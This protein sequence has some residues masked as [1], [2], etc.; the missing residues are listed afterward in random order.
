MKLQIVWFPIQT[1]VSIAPRELLLKQNVDLVDIWI[2]PSHTYACVIWNK[3][4][5]IDSRLSLTLHVTLTKSVFLCTCFSSS[6]KWRNRITGF[7]IFLIA[8]LLHLS[9]TYSGYPTWNLK[10]IERESSMAFLYIFYQVLSQP[11]LLS[12]F[13]VCMTNGFGTKIITSPSG[14]KGRFMSWAE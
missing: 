9:K 8:L 6:L 4:R 11:L 12:I 10:H 5:E 2:N 3:I 13:V 7:H 14:D 1:I